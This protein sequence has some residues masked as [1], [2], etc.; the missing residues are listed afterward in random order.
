LDDR[1]LQ[2]L[3]SIGTRLALGAYPLAFIVLFGWAFGKQAFDAAAAAANW[4]NYLNVF[5]PSGFALVPP[6][7][8]RW[9][10]DPGAPTADRQNLRDHLALQR[11]LSATA[12]AVGLGLWFAIEPAF[13]GLAERSGDL[14]RTWFPLFAV[15]AISQLSLTL[16]LGVTQALGRYRQALLWV[17]SPRA[18]A[19]GAVLGIALTPAGAT[20]GIAVAV[21]IVVAGQL[22][23]SADGRAAVRRVDPAVL[24]ER[25]NA[26]A[27]LPANVSAGAIALVGTL[28]T[29]A[30]VTIV[31]R[32]Q[33]GDVG[34]AHVIVTLSNAFGAV[35]VAAFF[36]GS[37]SLAARIDDP[38]AV[39]GH[40][41]RVARN[42]LALSAGVIALGWLLFPACP[43]VADRC[44]SH[45]FTVAS[46]VIAGAGMRLAT[47]GIYHGALM[48]GRPHLCLLSA[49]AEAAVVLVLALLLI[50]DLGLMAIGVA[51]AAGGAARLGVAFVFELP[52]VGRARP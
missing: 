3:A 23:L 12:L 48:R 49:V 46:L 18:L 32:A 34:T 51:F 16:W 40:A 19:L 6:A 26:V 2:V 39:R 11:W 44:E 30:P 24:D 31:G 35:V 8:A 27:V 42:V 50:G 52:R 25:G 28:V 1:R 5:L 4:A 33:P 7:V 21:A 20:A 41:L 9:R 22:M 37:I 43:A 45:W 14:L 17:A 10:A 47:L 29:I 38:A 13:P 36:P 15:L